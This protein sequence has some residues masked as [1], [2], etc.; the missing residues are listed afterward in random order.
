VHHETLV[1]VINIE[2]LAGQPLTEITHN[3]DTARP[4]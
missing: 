1:H 4:L 3:S 2:M